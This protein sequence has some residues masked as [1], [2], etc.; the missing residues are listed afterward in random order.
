MLLGHQDWLDGLVKKAKG[1]EIG[2]TNLE[3]IGF[4]V[5]QLGRREVEK[6]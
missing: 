5:R 1:E 6:P 3:K 2:L 4:P